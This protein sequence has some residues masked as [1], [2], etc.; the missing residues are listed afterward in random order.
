MHI[1]T[2][3]FYFY[4][5]TS[6]DFRPVSFLHVLS[7]IFFLL[8]SFSTLWAQSPDVIPPT[9]SPHSPVVILPTESAEPPTT[10]ASPPI[11]TPSPAA[12]PSSQQATPTQT[13]THVS[14]NPSPEPDIFPA[15]PKAVFANERETITRI[16]IFLDNQG[17]G[18][19]KI[20][21]GWGEF[22]AKA[23]DRWKIANNLPLESKAPIEQ[24]DPIYTQY[25]IREQDLK[26]VGSV[27]SSPEL[28][29]KLKSL[30]YQSLLEFITERYHSSPDFLQALN[31]N[32]NL[33]NLQPGDSVWVPNVAPFKIEELKEIAKLPVVETLKSRVIKIDLR[34]RMLD[35]YEGEKLIAAFPITPGSAQHPAPA[36]T[37]RI[38]NIT[39]LPWY[40][41]DEGVL[42]QGVRTSNYFNL[43]AGP[44]NPV[45]IL[46][47][48]INKPSIGIH[49]TNSPQTI[50]R[51]GSHGCIRL[52]NWDANRIY[53]LVTI[54]CTVEI[55]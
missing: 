23:L 7:G 52:A 37:W 19:G 47:M 24:I 4:F 39:I 43:P 30:P 20:D 31:P 10:H 32:L 48:A 27:P 34:Q 35:V 41:H 8:F 18:P 11:T 51:S 29:S 49:G 17:F 1:Q 44:N 45:G 6:C 53:E 38:T 54:G 46:W 12:A 22:T 13:L 50:G 21:G 15:A 25:T 9:P 55:R 16:Q 28:K 2:K 33:Y 40:R 14:Q 36:G 3:R 42:K 26:F 5:C